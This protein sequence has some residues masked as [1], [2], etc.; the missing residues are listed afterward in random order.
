MVK[1]PRIC[2]CHV[3]TKLSYSPSDVPSLKL[4]CGPPLRTLPGGF[5]Q[6]GALIMV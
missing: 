4:V 2:T 6:F 3:L 5:A 1:F